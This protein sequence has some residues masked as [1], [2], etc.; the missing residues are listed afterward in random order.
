MGP[1]QSSAAPT[2]TLT[3]RM[4]LSRDG[5]VVGVALGQGASVIHLDRPDQPIS[6]GPHQDVR[7]VSVSPDGQFVAT[8]SWYYGAKV[9]DAA[10]GKLVKDLSVGGLCQVVF[11]PDGRW[12]GT[13]SNGGQL[14]RVGTWEKGASLNGIG[15]TASGLMLAFTAP[16]PH[17]TSTRNRGMNIFWKVPYWR[18]PSPRASFA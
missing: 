13:S 7:F 15:N 1:P 14:W 6:L 4:A 16:L 9:W 11:S 17:P 10:S 3:R 18:C 5:R 12:L 8:G 2:S